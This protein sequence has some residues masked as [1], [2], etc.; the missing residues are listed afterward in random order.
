[1]QK[2]ATHRCGWHSKNSLNFFLRFYFCKRIWVSGIFHLF[3]TQM[4]IN[5]SRTEV[6]VSENI[7]LCPIFESSSAK[8]GYLF[9]I[10]KLLI[11]LPLQMPD[12]C[13]LLQSI[14]DQSSHT[15]LLQ[16]SL[17]L[18]VSKFLSHMHHQLVYLIS[19]FLFA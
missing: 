9:D 8:H 17:F 12:E 3:G 15:Q 16:W 6:F 1:M 14:Q 2:Y 13:F 11:D 5:L 18:L 19:F 7:T 4:R 10:T